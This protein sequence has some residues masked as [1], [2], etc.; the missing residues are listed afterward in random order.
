MVLPLVV[1]LVFAFPI[2]S[3][4]FILVLLCLVIILGV[5]A[6]IYNACGF[7]DEDD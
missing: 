5:G 2:A 3:L 6:A 7:D 4:W 1:L